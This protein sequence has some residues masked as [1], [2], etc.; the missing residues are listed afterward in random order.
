M[1]KKERLLVIAIIISVFGFSIFGTINPVEARTDRGAVVYEVGRHERSRVRAHA[2]DLDV[3]TR[4]YREHRD[5]FK[6]TKMVDMLSTVLDMSPEDI[7]DALSN[8]ARPKDMLADAGI[9]MHD[10]MEEFNFEL[11]GEREFVKF[12]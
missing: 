10:L 6:H 4:C 8:G 5:S 1:T 2:N 12:R 3:E 11:V 7:E 9:A